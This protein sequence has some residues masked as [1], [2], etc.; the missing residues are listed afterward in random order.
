MK[1][2][3][4]SSYKFDTTKQIPNPFL[5]FSPPPYAFVA[6]YSL[7]EGE[8]LWPNVSVSSETRRCDFEL[9]GGKYRHF[10]RKIVSSSISN[11]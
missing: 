4:N 6:F 2:C 10:C 9:R 5:V 8:E 11:L 7:G 3:C 1:H